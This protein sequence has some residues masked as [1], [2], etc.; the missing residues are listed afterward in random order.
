MK[1]KGEKENESATH[2]QK[3]ACTEHQRKKV[4]STPLAVSNSG[5]FEELFA[6]TGNLSKGAAVGSDKISLNSYMGG[7]GSKQP[8][9]VKITL[10]I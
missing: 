3:V 2:Q 6:S 5:S 7:C 10:T 4:L 1:K 9:W 8:K